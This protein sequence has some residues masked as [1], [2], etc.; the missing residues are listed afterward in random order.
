[1][2]A[3]FKCAGKTMLNIEG[4]L[5]MSLIRWENAREKALTTKQGSDRYS[6]FSDSKGLKKRDEK[7]DTE[8]GR[9]LFRHDR[10]LSASD[11]PGGG[12]SP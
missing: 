3:L 4:L 5:P 12:V 9:A 1:M 10:G 7:E 11:V 6:C 8:L 2:Q